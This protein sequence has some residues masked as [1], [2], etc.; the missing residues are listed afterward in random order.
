EL[1]ETMKSADGFYVGNAGLARIGAILE[2]TGIRAP[3]VGFD[4]TEPV[5]RLLSRGAISAVI[6]EHRYLQGYF[7]VQKAYE[8][9][10]KRKQG[11]AIAGIRIPSDVAFAANAADSADSLHFAF[12]TLVRQRT[13]A[14]VSYKQRLEEANAELL[15]LAITDPLT[16]LL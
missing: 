8:A 7:A 1:V 11:A 5:E 9:I 13:E 3:C 14:L 16:G 2:Q 4:K 15:G 6:V 12:E 10:V